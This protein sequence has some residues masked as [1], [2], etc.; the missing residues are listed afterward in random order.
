MHGRGEAS[1][2]R[3]DGDGVQTRVC[4]WRGGLAQGHYEIMLGASETSSRSVS[5]KGGEGAVR[6][7]L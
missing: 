3:P 5:Y 1:L 6:G 7:E 2:G 4:S